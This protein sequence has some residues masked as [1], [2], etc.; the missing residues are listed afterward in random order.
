[1]RSAALVSLLP[2]LATLATAA[3]SPLMSRDLPVRKSLS[4]GPKHEHASFETFDLG[5]VPSV[6][7]LQH[8]SPEEVAA[9]FLATRFGRDGFY[10]RDDVSGVSLVD[11]RY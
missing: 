7:L 6:G 1:M 10:I 3:P 5:D 11:S 8:A 9:E 4:F 2:L